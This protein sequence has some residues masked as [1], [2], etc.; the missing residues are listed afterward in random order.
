ML[1]VLPD[2][3]YGLTEDV[4]NLTPSQ[5][6][7]YARDLAKMSND[8]Y[9]QMSR[10]GFKITESQKNILKGTASEVDLV[11]ELGTSYRNMSEDMRKAQVIQDIVS[12]NWGGL[13]NAM[14]KT[15]QAI[16]ESIKQSLTTLR[17]EFGR[18]I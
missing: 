1:Q 5:L 8:M 7:N 6:K 15:P 10:R 9:Y 4:A 16:S 14:N 17:V 11:K 12:N 18:E 3:A 13:A 2:Y